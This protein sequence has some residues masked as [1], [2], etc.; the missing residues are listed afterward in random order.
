MNNKL[1]YILIN[2]YE[3]KDLRTFI[4]ENFDYKLLSYIISNKNSFY[5]TF[6]V[7][8]KNGGFREI[9]QPLNKLFDIQKEFSKYL[10]VKRGVYNEISH[11]F[12]LNKS[13]LTNAQKH[14][15]K[16]IV[17][18]IDIE[19][20]FLNISKEHVSEVLS[21]KFNLTKF[22]SN[23]IADLLTFNNHLPQGSP[24]SPII[25][26]YVC[27]EL[28]ERLR[29][30][31][32]QYNITY[33][34]YADDLTFSFHF[35][36]LPIIQVTEIILIIE[37]LKFKINRKKFRWFYQNNRQTVTGL[38]VNSE[39]NVKREFYKNIRAILWNWENKGLEWSLEEFNKKYPKRNNFNKTVKGWIDYIGF[40]K[41]KKH[42]Y[43]SELN[44]KYNLLNSRL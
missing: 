1:F 20:F 14:I 33:S 29:N 35:D 36:R 21:E 28:D 42:K 24:S 8:K 34:R 6:T 37:D 41:G 2:K 32:K 40:I 44:A 16:K 18:N 3:S 26:N 12:E 11:G 5:K 27:D 22:E 31:C 15:N 4:S 25:S 13:I 7:P 23:Y 43:Y 17:L 30:Y 38:V 39:V 19:D 9:N 10:I